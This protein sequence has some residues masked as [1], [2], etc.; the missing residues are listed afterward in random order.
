MW[1]DAV[2]TWFLR[3]SG[4]DDAKGRVGHHAGRV[5]AEAMQLDG[6][7]VIA[8]SPWEAASGGKAIACAAGTCRAGL[9]FDGKAGWYT[10]C[11]QYF[12]QNNGAAHFRLLVGDQVVDQWTA[13]AHLPTIKLDGT[14]SMRRTLN[15]IA[16]RPGDE[17]R[18][19]GS[20][21]G[22]DT[23]AIDYLEILPSPQ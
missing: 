20:P 13:D 19:E 16:L 22:G 1:R 10:L 9:R 6:Y 12:D 2:S 15:G 3:E 14:S 7:S 17:I 4:I 11:V 5:E 21:D 8:V 18:V 23:A